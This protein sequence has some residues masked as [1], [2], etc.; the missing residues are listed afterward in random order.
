MFLIFNPG[1]L[2]AVVSALICTTG[3]TEYNP[4]IDAAFNPYAVPP[5][6]FVN[7][8]SVPVPVPSETLYRENACKFPPDVTP[9]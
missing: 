4:L 5:L 9:L 3:N 8:K 1:L 6:A 2:N 7:V